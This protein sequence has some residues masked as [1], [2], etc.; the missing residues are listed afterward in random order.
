[1]Y[2]IDMV[3]QLGRP[4][5]SYAERQDAPS[6]NKVRASNVT[7]RGSDDCI[8]PRRQANT[9]GWEGGHT[10]LLLKGTHILSSE[11]GKL[12]FRWVENMATKPER[13]AGVAISYSL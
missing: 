10:R 4:C 12:I 11:V 3:W 6:D 2:H 1:M 13:I 7:H 5:D 9:C 8:V